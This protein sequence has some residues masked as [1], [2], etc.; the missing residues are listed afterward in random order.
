MR[1]FNGVFKEYAT[2]SS[3]PPLYLYTGDNVPLPKC[4]ITCGL[5]EECD[6]ASWGHGRC[7][8]VNNPDW[9]SSVIDYNSTGITVYHIVL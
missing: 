5:H 6:A 1:R 4:L 7:Q 8:H 3:L 9:K 2:D